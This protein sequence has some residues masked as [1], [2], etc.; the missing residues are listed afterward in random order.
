MVGLRRP[1]LASYLDA[2]R[3]VAREGPNT[4]RFSEEHRWGEDLDQALN[5]V[6]ALNLERQT[7][8]QA[9]ETVPWPEGV[10]FDHI[11][12]LRILRF[13]GVGPPPPGL[14][15]DEETPVPEGYSE[16]VVRWTIFGA[17]G[18]RVRAQ[19]VT[20]HRE[21]GW[22]VTDY[23]DLAAKL[24]TSLVVLAN[25]LGTRLQAFARE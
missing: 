9:A 13:E 7:G 15:A 3:M 8:I 2:A 17:E 25:D 18:E 5:R 6:V 24:D 4:V 10:V 21:D 23:A 1:Q 22:P 14:E 20:R 12:Q 16:M 11:V 19:G